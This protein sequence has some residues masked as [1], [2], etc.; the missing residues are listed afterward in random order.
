MADSFDGKLDAIAW[1]PFG[2]KF[3][4]RSRDR[5]P[6]NCPTRPRCSCPPRTW[7]VK[8]LAFAEPRNHGRQIPY[9]GHPLFA[10][11]RTTDRQREARRP[12]APYSILDVYGRNLQIRTLQ[13]ALFAS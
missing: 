10:P 5:S 6:P 11:C 12:V 13:R 1:H 7:L 9:R 8:R 4:L 3:H 2:A